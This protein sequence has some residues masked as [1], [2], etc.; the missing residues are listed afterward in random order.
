MKEKEN[1]P[2]AAIAGELV[3]HV[4]V[5]EPV[6]GIVYEYELH[7]RF[8][9][10]IT[11]A[12]VNALAKNWVPDRNRVITVSA[13]E[14]ALSALKSA[15]GTNKGH[16]SFAITCASACVGA[17]GINH[18]KFVLFSHLRNRAKVF[19]QSSANM[20][21]GNSANSGINAWNNA[22]TIVDEPAVYDAYV[23]R[24][25]AIA[26]K[27]KERRQLEARF[28]KENQFNRKVELNAALRSLSQELESLKQF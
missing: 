23:A 19:V 9:P 13:P 10:E 21:E 11:L 1:T 12:E 17:V 18:H 2:A 6:P 4:T 28:D 14:K 24:F 20:L 7:Q 27:E 8:L 15:L 22:V 25:N 16:A 26:A 5:R 3:R